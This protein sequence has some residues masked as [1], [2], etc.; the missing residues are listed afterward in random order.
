[1]R[2]ITGSARGRKLE[3]LPGMDT[4]PTTD[5]LK[6][7]MFTIIQFDV[8]GRRVL[9]LFAG[10][11]QLGIEALSRGADSATFVDSSP[12]A[13][14]VVRRN[15]GRTGLTE[16]ARVV[17]SDYRAFLKSCGEQFGLV[18]ID[19][20]YESGGAREALALIAEFDILCIGGIIMCETGRG[21]SLPEGAGAL[22]KG[23]EYVYGDKKLTL[24]TRRKDDI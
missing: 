22:V 24:Y 15:L 13:L 4:R 16:R 18:F 12:G 11:G 2:V 20:P 1:M 23:R 17:R 5:R 6:E 7:T 14:G 3:A 10:T 8:E 9:D 21:T 19:P